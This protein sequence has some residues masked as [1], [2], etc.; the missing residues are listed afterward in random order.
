MFE[1]CEFDCV[2]VF[3]CAWHVEVCEMSSELIHVMLLLCEFCV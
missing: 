1:C 2:D 3:C